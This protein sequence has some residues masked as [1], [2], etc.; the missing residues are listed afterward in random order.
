MPFRLNPRIFPAVVSATV[1]A[2]EAITTP[3]PQPPVANSVFGDAPVAGCAITLLGRMTEPAT[4]A[5]TVTKPPKKE[6]LSLEKGANRSLE[7]FCTGGFFIKLS[8]AHPASNG[9]SAKS[10]YGTKL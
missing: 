4:P 10:G 2:S 8:L 9:Q 7:S 1:A 6:R 5:P 3:R